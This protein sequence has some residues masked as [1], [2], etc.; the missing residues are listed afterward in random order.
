MGAVRKLATVVIVG[1][2]AL[3]T[4]LVVYL[5]AEPARRDDETTEQQATSIERGTSLY[6]TYCLQ[7][8]GPAGLG[9]QEKD[10]NG[11]PLGRTGAVLNQNAIMNEEQLSGARAIFQSDDPVQQGIAEDWI[12]FRIMYGAPPEQM[13]QG[14]D[15]PILMPSFRRDLN[16]E[17][18]NDLVYLI[19][20][21]DWNYVYNTAVHDTGIT[22]AQ[23]QCMATPGADAAACEAID[24]APPAYPTVPPPAEEPDS[25][26]E[27]EEQSGTPEAQPEQDPE[28][29]ESA[30]GA[31]GEEGEGDGGAAPSG[32]GSIEIE[33]LDSLA[34]S[35][36]E[37]TV[38]PGDTITLTNAGFLQH[39]LAVDDWGGPLTPM[40]NNGESAE[41]TIPEDAEPGEYEFYCS[42]PGH[43]EGGMVGTF[44]VEAP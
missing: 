24:D 40:L 15:G 37:I 39:D 20:Y 9:S 14:Y 2:V 42:V 4:L 7:C 10:E 33:S 41:F 44:T 22:L 13:T 1:L 34:F 11:E 29:D 30:G 35:E 19:M 18:I 12:R 26:S 23:Q 36:T 28:A 6:I 32:G 25:A 27:A 38:K 3:S 17:Q 5:A 21:G 16:V 31:S 8:H 43:K